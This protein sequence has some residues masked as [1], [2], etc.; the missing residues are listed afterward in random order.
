MKDAES[1]RVDVFDDGFNKVASSPSVKS[2]EWQLNVPLHRGGVY[3]WQVTAMVNGEE[4]RSPVRPAPDAK[5][6]VL[7]AVKADHLADARA[8]YGRS[9]LLLGILY[10]DAGLMPEAERELQILISKNPDSAAARR[11]LEKVK[12]SR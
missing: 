9:H 2:V 10:A 11:L 4:V 5:F 8:R 12:A 7:D 6:K 1:Y 3:R